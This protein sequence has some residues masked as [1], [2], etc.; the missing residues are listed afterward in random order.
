M[1]RELQCILVCFQHLCV[2]VDFSPH[3]V[4]VARLCCEMS[5]YENTSEAKR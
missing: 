4:V 5:S 1:E 2:E 3:A